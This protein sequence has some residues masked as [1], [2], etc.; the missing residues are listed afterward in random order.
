MSGIHHEILIVSSAEKIYEAL[1]TQSGLASWWTPKTI[2]E[3]EAGSVS[4]FPFGE[5]YFKEMRIEELNFPKLVRWTC[6]SGTYEWVGTS[7]SFRLIS[8]TRETILKIHPEIL[9]QLTQSPEGKIVTLLIFQ[10]DDW[11]ADTPMF[12]ECNY[13]WGQFL[14]SLKLYCE[15]GKGRPWPGQ[16][17]E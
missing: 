7:I 17:G 5:N 2:A 16:H 14:R 15:T 3:P 11:K 13:T 9:D 4:K 10:H 8:G 6:I 1:T 12:A